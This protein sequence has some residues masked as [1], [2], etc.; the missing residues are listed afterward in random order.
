M[1]LFVT[2]ELDSPVDR[3][4]ARQFCWRRCKYGYV[5]DENGCE[6]C[7][8]SMYNCHTFTCYVMDLYLCNWASFHLMMLTCYTV[9]F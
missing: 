7:Q 2:E 4:G 3:C 5:K 1:D 9:K 8:C 6:T